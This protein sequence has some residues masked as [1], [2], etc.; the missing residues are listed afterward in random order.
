MLQEPVQKEPECQDGCHLLPGF[1]EPEQ[2]WPGLF[3]ACLLGKCSKKSNVLFSMFSWDDAPRLWSLQANRCQESDDDGSSDSSSSSSSSRSSRA[4]WLIE[5]QDTCFHKLHVLTL[6][7]YI[8]YLARP[9]KEYLYV[10][11]LFCSYL[12][13]A[14]RG[15]LERKNFPRGRC[16]EIWTFFSRLCL[17]MFYF[18]QVLPK[19]F[20]SQFFYCPV[21]WVT[22][23]LP[24]CP[25]AQTT[26][27]E[28]VL[29]VAE[30]QLLCSNFCSIHIGALQRP[31]LMSTLVS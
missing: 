13:L 17:K 2:I 24:N 9:W 12:A 29:V 14:G 20:L 5:G 23:Q 4:K 25:S 6:P 22:F 1:L 3:V 8:P 7:K 21:N 15:L 28:L 19:F 26:F 10:E 30:R 16:P 11:Q 18:P 27:K 31:F